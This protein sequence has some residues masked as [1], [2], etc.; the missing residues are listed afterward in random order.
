[1]N[2]RKV[3][4]R[5]EEANA[6]LEEMADGV[7]LQWLN[8]GFD[9]MGDLELEATLVL[10]NRMLEEFEEQGMDG[11]E[12]RELL[13]NRRHELEEESTKR[14]EETLAFIREQELRE[15]QREQEAKPGGVIKGGFFPGSPLRH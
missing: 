1:M 6:A 3:P 4:G 9:R 10:V 5:N 7:N 15:W 14:H 13:L 12:E 8:R 2:E 11:D